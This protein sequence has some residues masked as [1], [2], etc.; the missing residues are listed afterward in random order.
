VFRCFLFYYGAAIGAILSDNPIGR[1]LG[2]LGAQ[3]LATL[4]NR[5]ARLIP[6]GTQASKPQDAHLRETNVDGLASTALLAWA[7]DRLDDETLRQIARDT[8]RT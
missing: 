3:E 4:Y 1:E 5:R 7:A 2:L 8:R 6:I